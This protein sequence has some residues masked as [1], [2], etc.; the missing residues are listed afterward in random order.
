[1]RVQYTA[2]DDYGNRFNLPHRPRRLI[3][4]APSVT[5]ILFAIGAGNRVVGVTN[6][7]DYPC[8]SSS[9]S[10]ARK[11]VRVGS[12]LSPS[13]EK[14]VS[15]KPDIVFLSRIRCNKG[16]GKNGLGCSRKCR[17]NLQVAEKLRDLGLSP[18]IL[19][20]ESVEHIFK[21]I[22]KVG[23]VIGNERVAR[24]LVVKNR[25]RV[26]EKIQDLKNV[27]YRPK[28]YFEV[29]N[30]PLMSVGKRTW[31]D[32]LINLAW[33][34]NIIECENCRW[35]IISSDEVIRLNPEVIVFPYIEDVLRFWGSFED[36]KARPGWEDISAVQN[37][38][39]YEIRRDLISRPGPRVVEALDSMMRAIHPEIG[40]SN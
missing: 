7:C 22:I 8:D 24:A 30:E 40:S 9:Y 25:Q 11:L 14:I 38:R 13:T 35:P 2:V 6:H 26:E 10:K 17:S 12:Y 36:V 3:S 4:L 1:L 34:T 20:P 5:E 19:S 28:V 32:D 31:I 29:W 15:L 21:D 33:G 27:S 23:K 37:D 16:E 18:F 39:L